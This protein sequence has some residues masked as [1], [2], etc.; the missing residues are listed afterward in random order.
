M[1]LDIRRAKTEDY[2]LKAN[3]NYSSRSKSSQPGLHCK[4]PSQKQSRDLEALAFLTPDTQV[5][6]CSSQSPGSRDHAHLKFC[7]STR[8]AIKPVRVSLC[9]I[10]SLSAVCASRSTSRNKRKN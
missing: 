2:E 4:T 9:V 6:Q 8:T 10:R 1:I 3:L 7:L 5:L